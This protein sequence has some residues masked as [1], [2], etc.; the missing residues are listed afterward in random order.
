MYIQRQKEFEIVLRDDIIPFFKS[1]KVT[2]IR[3]SEGDKEL[4]DNIFDDIDFDVS[5]LH[6]Y[7]AMLSRNFLSCWTRLHGKPDYDQ[8]KSV[9]TGA[10]NV[11][12]LHTLLF[13]DWP[14]GEV[15]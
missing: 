8:M 15:F 2:L 13:A 11:D 4:I 3:I 5:E 7:S 12:Y 14:A 6:H 1:L 9:V 10:P